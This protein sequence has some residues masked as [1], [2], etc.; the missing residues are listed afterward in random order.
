VNRSHLRLTLTLAAGLALGSGAVA[1][2]FAADS[3]SGAPVDCSKADAMM[4]PMAMHGAMMKEGMDDDS[5]HGGDMHPMMKPTGNLDADFAH[6]MMMHNTMAM[7]AA[8]ME[9]AC[10]KNQKVKDLAK[11]MMDQASADDAILEDLLKNDNKI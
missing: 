11:K 2:A 7:H 4:M 6:M 8:K 5:M 9:M 3:M 10:G 1:P